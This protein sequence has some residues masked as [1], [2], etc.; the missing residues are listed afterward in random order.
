M[1]D[2]FAFVLAG[3]L[4]FFMMLMFIPPI[5]RTV[6]RVVAEKN[7]RAK[8]SMRM[9]GMNDA[10]YWLSWFCYFTLVNTA[11]CSLSFIVLYFGAFRYTS[12]VLLFL[13][14]W[15]FGQSLFGFIM[16]AQ[17][18]FTT[19]RA[20]AITT[21]IVYFGTSMLNLFV[22]DDETPF[23]NRFAMSLFVPTCA[24][25]QT[26]KVFVQFESN[27]VGITMSTWNTPY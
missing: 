10:P 20:A 24:M 22:D 7:N 12:P 13:N 11:L 9:M 19:P 16:I 14:F 8:E 5:Y 1:L 27:G 2:P 18:I 6:Y 25:L 21:T 23:E 26:V 17:S 4:N 15:L 3:S